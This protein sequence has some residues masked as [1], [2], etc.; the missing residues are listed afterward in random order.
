MGYIKYL[1][2]HIFAFLFCCLYAQTESTTSRDSVYMTCVQC[3]SLYNRI[4]PDTPIIFSDPENF[5]EFP[6][7]EIELLN[8]IKKNLEYPRECKEKAIQGR[9]IIKFI[10]NESG[11]IICP[12]IHMSLHPALDKEVLRIVKLMPDWM[13]ASKNKVPCNSCYTLPISFML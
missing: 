5:P 9:V 3:D 2:L 10:I 4:C 6:G 11:K 7:G 8:F 12:Y 1:L 13:P